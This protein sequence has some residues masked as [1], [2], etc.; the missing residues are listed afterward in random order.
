M[1][2]AAVLVTLKVKGLRFTGPAV[3][4]PA[5]DKRWGIPGPW[6]QEV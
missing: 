4:T 2:A 6:A 1:V 3:I 5:A